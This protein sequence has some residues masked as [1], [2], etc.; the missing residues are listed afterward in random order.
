MFSTLLKGFNWKS[1]GKTKAMVAAMICSVGLVLGAGGRLLLA[2]SE[3][4]CNNEGLKPGPY[5]GTG[6]K[7]VVPCSGN[8][9]TVTY[10]VYSIYSVCSSPG[11]S[12]GDSCVVDNQKTV[13]TYTSKGCQNGVCYQV[14]TEAYS[15]VWNY[16]LTANCST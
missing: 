1:S 14:Y 12:D 7:L 4:P 2:T 3:P 11:T 8:S 13:D 15:Y 6:P 16:Q 10:S 9:C 5:S